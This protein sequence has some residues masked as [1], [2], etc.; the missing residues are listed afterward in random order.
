MSESYVREKLYGWVY[1]WEWC[2]FD[3]KRN[4]TME[5]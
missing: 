3:G 1:H 4:L 2:K 5:A